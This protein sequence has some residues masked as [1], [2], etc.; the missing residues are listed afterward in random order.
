MK[1]IKLTPDKNNQV[2]LIEKISSSKLQK[3]VH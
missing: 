1:I 2:F 3:A